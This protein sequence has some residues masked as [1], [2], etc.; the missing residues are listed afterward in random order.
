MNLG[1]QSLVISR[2]VGFHLLEFIHC[3][4]EAILFVIVNSV[5]SVDVSIKRVG[6]ERGVKNELR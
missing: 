3:F 5:H 1:S 6:N 2:L 4:T